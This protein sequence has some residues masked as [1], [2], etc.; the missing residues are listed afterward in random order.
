MEIRAATAAEAPGLSV[1]LAE[2]GHPVDAQEL[3]ARLGA[4][5]QAQATALVAWQ[6]GPPSGLVLLHWYPGLFSP[7]PVAQIT[8]LL[9]ATDDRRRGVGRMLVKAA[10]QAARAAGC[11]DMELAVPDDAPGL[12]AFCEATGFAQAGLRFTRSLRRR[13]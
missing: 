1:L 6:W 8:T 3:A 12:A 2:A 11:N 7:R 9:V 4:L 10:A 5:R 13:S